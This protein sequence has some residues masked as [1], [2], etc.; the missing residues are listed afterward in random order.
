MALTEKEAKEWA[1]IIVLAVIAIGIVIL[2]IMIAMIHFHQNMFWISMVSSFV[3]LILFIGHSE[4]F[5]L[6]S[7]V[8]AGEGNRG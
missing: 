5:R 3:F 4:N 6:F 1:V 8:R 7:V 2:K